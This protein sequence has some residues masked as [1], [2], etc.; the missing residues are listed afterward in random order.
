MAT[1]GGA[2]TEV[3]DGI[4]PT[5]DCSNYLE[6]MPPPMKLGARGGHVT[7]GAALVSVPLLRRAAKTCT[8]WSSIAQRL[9]RTMISWTTVN[10]VR[11]TRR[12]SSIV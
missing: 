8:A 3:S 2:S 11:A 4:I 10:V 5:T 6:N 7:E 12:L 9:S 1:H